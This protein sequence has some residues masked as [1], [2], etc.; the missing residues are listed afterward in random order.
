VSDD[1]PCAPTSPV[2]EKNAAAVELG[3]RGGLAP[4]AE[5]P[6]SLWA[7]QSLRTAA[8]RLAPALRDLEH[9]RPPGLD[10]GDESLRCVAIDP[11][12][13]QSGND[14]F[15]ADESPRGA[16]AD[17]ELIGL[18]REA[19]L[20][21]E[22]PGSEG[23]PSP[24]T[25]PPCRIDVLLLDDDHLPDLRASHLPGEHPPAPIARDL[26]PPN[27]VVRDGGIGHRAAGLSMRA[28]LTARPSS[29]R[30][31]SRSTV[32]PHEHALQAGPHPYRTGSSPGRRQ[33]EHVQRKRGGSTFLTMR[34]RLPP[35]AGR[36][37]G[38]RAGRPPCESRP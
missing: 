22:R 23:A 2:P 31:T 32:C 34:R 3:G 7:L 8:P 26:E 36:H 4:G 12:L 28:T 16:C 33:R 19:Q 37:G 20:G 27:G 21:M 30:R 29:S 11:E 6:R 24:Q 5:V 9:D 14:G 38:I 10:A 17:P 35:G 13:A 18:A 1:S 15:P 25:R